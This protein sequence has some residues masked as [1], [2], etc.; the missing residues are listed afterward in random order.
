[1]EP[2]NEA[3]A[4]DNSLRFQEM[5]S[6]RMIARITKCESKEPANSRKKI[7]NVDLSFNNR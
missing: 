6:M 4:S 2:D 1:M 7:R 5:I 3:I